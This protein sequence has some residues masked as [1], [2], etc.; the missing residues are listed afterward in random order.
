MSIDK[1]T[2]PLSWDD[3]GL[4]ISVT[5]AFTVNRSIVENKTFPK[6][7]VLGE[8]SYFTLLFLGIA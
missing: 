5:K 3:R 2:V 8:M 7:Y 6:P 1:V 4:D